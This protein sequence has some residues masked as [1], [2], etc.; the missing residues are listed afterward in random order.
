MYD[1]AESRVRVDCKYSDVYSVK[2]GVHQGPLL[3]LIVFEALSRE[4]RTG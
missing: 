1:N 2:V 3:F 4:F